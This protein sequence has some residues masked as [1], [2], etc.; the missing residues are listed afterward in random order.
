VIEEAMI[1]R[2]RAKCRVIQLKEEDDYSTPM[3]QRGVRGHGI[4]YPQGPSE[5]AKVLPSS[6]DDVMTRICVIFVGSNPLT[7]ERLQKK[8]KPLTVRKE[9]VLNALSWLKTH[10]PLYK[11]LEINADVFDGQPDETVCPFHVQQVVPSSGIVASTSS[12]VPESDIADSVSTTPNSLPL[13]SDIL[14][15]PASAP[16]PFDSVVV[17]ASQTVRI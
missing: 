3:T 16:I 8:A 6:I 5:I 4:A 1:A 13:L 15:R 2:C 14:N 12:D 7:S 10:N 11:D 17:R 9:K